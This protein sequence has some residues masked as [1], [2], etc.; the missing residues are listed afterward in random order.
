MEMEPVE[1]QYRKNRRPDILAVIGAIEAAG[2]VWKAYSKLGTS[3]N[4]PTSI[5]Y[6]NGVVAGLRAATDKSELDYL[7]RMAT[8]ETRTLKALAD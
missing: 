1:E 8:T 6:W 4:F 3:M 2:E 7:V 5:G